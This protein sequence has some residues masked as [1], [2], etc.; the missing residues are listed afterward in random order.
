MGKAP[1]K[2]KTGQKYGQ[3]FLFD[4]S[5]LERMVGGSGVEKDDTVLEIGPGLGPLTAVLARRAGRVLAVEID[6]GLLERLRANLAGYDNVEI[7]HADI[8]QVDLPALWREKLGGGAFRV[9]ANLPYYIT[10]PVIMLLLESGLPIRSITVM[11]QREVAQRLVAQPGTKEYG[12]ISASAVYRADVKLLFRV[13]AGAFVPPPKVESAVL[14]L[15]M[16]PKSRIAVRDEGLLLRVIRC[17]FAMRRKTMKN[18]LAASFG[19]TGEQAEA[20]LLQVGL[21]KNVRGEAL[22]LAQYA[23]LADVLVQMGY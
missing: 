22:C 13:P 18:N 20:L 7:L 2:T 12:A 23:A 8:M 16:L 15:T 9:V 14:H 4:P 17:A 6:S 3:H 19:M 21:E 10:T 1:I 11:V 5:I